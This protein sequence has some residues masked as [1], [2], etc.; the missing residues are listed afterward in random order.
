MTQ[1][2]E[3]VLELEQRIKVLENQASPR[4]PGMKILWFLIW[5]CVIQKGSKY[6]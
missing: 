4:L 1:E 2:E 3:K 6:R 5:G